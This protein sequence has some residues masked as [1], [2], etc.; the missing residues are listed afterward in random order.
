MEA[1][2]VISRTLDSGDRFIGMYLDGLEDSDLLIRPVEGMNHIAWQLGHLIASEW[3]MIGAIRPG[4]CP[5]LPEGFAEAHSK[6]KAASDDPKNFLP[7][8]EYVRLASIQREA[9]KKVL[10]ELSS[11]DLDTPSPE[12]L[13][14]FAPTV[15]SVLLLVGTH[16]LM[17]VGQFVGVRRK[18]GKSA[19]I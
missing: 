9:T 11:S 8:A 2:D 4:A 19:Q 7:K 6:D 15:G 12:P 16:H 17:H 1:K 13:A 14:K 10:S 3:R 5:A 18:L